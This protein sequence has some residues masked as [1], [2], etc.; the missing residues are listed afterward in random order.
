MGLEVNHGIEGYEYGVISVIIFIRLFNS[1]NVQELI[2]FSSSQI[3]I[4]LLEKYF[5]S[6]NLLPI[7]E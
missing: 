5:L 1:E 2:S 6:I 4:L 3:I 7:N